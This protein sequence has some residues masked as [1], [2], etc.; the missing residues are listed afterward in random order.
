M[1]GKS[2]GHFQIEERLGAG[3]M[4]VVYRARDTQLDRPVALKLVGEKYAQDAQARA[5]L[6]NEARTASALNHPHICHI[7][8]V[9]EAE[10]GAYIAMEYV[11]GKPLAQVI[12]QDGLPLEAVLRYGIQIA[13][14]VAHAHE[15]NIIHRDLKSANVMITPE[16]R[17]KVLDFGLAR[18]QRGEE[19][20]EVTRSQVS[21]AATA[22]VSGTL[23]AIAPEVLCGEPSDPRSD[24][25]AL[26]VLLYEMATGRLPFEGKT[27]YEMSSA[28]LREQPAPLP[29]RVPAAL[30][31]VI[32]RC[33][34]KD[35]AQRF[36]R[37]SEVRASLETIQSSEES[38][39]VAPTAAP[40]AAL[41]SVEGSR[42]FLYGAIVGLAVVLLAILF[43]WNPR[44]W[45]N[46]FSA[47]PAEAPIRS[48]AVLPMKNLNPAG[49]EDV[50]GL[51]MADTII[52]KV[53]QIGAL[54]V[55][56]T[57]AVQ[58]YARQETEALEAA[59]QLGV[60]SVL[61]GTVQR[62]GDRLR[63]NVN[64]LR[65]R[66]GASL[67]SDTFNVSAG[68]IFATQDE[69]AQKVAAGLRLKLNTSEQARVTKRYT[70]SPEAYEF[71]VRGIRAL[72]RRSLGF[73]SDREPLDLAIAMFGKALEADPKYALAQAQL[74]YA[75][76]WVALFLD[77]SPSWME[78]AKRSLARAEALDP[79]LAE[80]HLVR[81]EMAWSSHEGY[82]IEKAVQELQLAQQLN[83][84]VGHEHLGILFAHIGLEEPAVREMRRAIE[85]DPQ[86]EIARSRLVETYDLVVRP[87]E[88]LRESEMLFGSV[89]TLIPAYM[90]KSLLWTG[91][92]E[93]ARQVMEDSLAKTPNDPFVLSEKA[94]YQALTGD[95]RAAEAAIPG[96]VERGKTS[97]AF[98][99]LTYNVA[100]IYALQGKSALAV[101][102]LRKTV[103]TGMPNYILFAR[104]PHL[105]KIRKDRGF[106]EFMAELKPRFEKYQ[107]EFR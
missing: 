95:I 46:R 27:G 71:Y 64:L 79:E 91:Q 87:Q 97:R 83:P 5:R 70:S 48:L 84:S 54:T 99:H 7:Y 100:S 12:P 42:R 19:F 23:H 93:S 76:T 88:A 43:V 57:S 94:L 37:A 98:H 72:G 96:F 18:R 77:P 44:G 41:G 89:N 58:K 8:E 52:T 67:W 55:R 20:A 36:A 2:L 33:L 1:I 6:L 32:L 40:A 107:Q 61:D 63:V 31:A 74:A 17:V 21:L 16:G 11:A 15:H 75:E 34:A 14:A 105:D 24:V 60:D 13:D 51:G 90:R 28:I 85:I 66:D 101:E 38:I 50:L 102:W 3:G 78:Q 86:S 73:D 30:R 9:G 103:D 10:G 25:W 81:Y 53:S 26:G 39:P 82:N 56:P 45:R 49:G 35:A 69:I 47:A 104:D 92:L 59:R 22:T 65:V 106:V 29:P 68:D 62:S 4:G 80:S